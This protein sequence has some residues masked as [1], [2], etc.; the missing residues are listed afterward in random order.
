MP[1]ASRIQTVVS[2]ASG[3]AL[4]DT[5]AP[6]QSRSVTSNSATTSTAPIQ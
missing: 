3:I 4:K 1:K 5:S 2:S 6:R